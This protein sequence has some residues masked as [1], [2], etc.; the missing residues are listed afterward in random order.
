M[1]IDDNA[2]NL[3]ESESSTSFTSGVTGENFFHGKEKP[4]VMVAEGS[5]D[6]ST[7][8]H[9]TLLREGGDYDL[10][11]MV[12]SRPMDNRDL[13]EYMRDVLFVDET[14][15]KDQV[16][17]GHRKFQ[18][19][20][21]SATNGDVRHQAYTARATSGEWRY[22]GSVVPGYAQQ[23]QPT[24]LPRLAGKAQARHVAKPY[25]QKHPGLYGNRSG[26]DQDYQPI[27]AVNYENSHSE[28][29]NHSKIVRTR[30]TRRGMTWGKES[31]YTNGV[32]TCGAACLE[33][34]ANPRVK[35]NT[36]YP[37]SPL[38]PL[39]S[40]ASSS[41]SSKVRDRPKPY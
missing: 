22:N 33:S 39:P 4:S 12:G 14:A 11:F 21:R 34:S 28:E 15:W 5:F 36:A 10:Q 40:I 9:S 7:G 23:Q 37:A 32:N 27:G 24:N 3:L 19:N 20:H 1:I 6:P 41:M 8:P 18:F 16:E 25:Y 31:T 13:E 2:F 26:R 35:Q 29:P 30:S 38:W 17:K